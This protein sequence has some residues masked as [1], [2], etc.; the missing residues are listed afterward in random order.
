MAEVNKPVVLVV[1]DTP[2]NI[3]ILNELLGKE[4]LVRAATSG[5]AALEMVHTPPQPDLILL[6]I[7]MPEMDGYEVCIELKKNPL[8]AHIPV[9]FV[10]AM[11]EED[12]EAKG[13]DLG[14]ADYITKPY[15]PRLVLARVHNHLA[16]KKNRDDLY[17]MVNQR[18]DEIYRT[19]SITIETLASL[20]ETRDPETGRHIRRTQRYVRMLARELRSIYPTTWPLS[21]PLIDLIYS[22]APLH[23]IGKVGIPDTILLKPGALTVD[24]FEIMKLHTVYGYGALSSAE[25][26]LG[27]SSFLRVGAEIAYTHHEKWD[28][29]GYP[30]QLAGTDI[31]MSGRLMALADVYD[32]LV[33]KRVYK[34]PLTHEE[35]S[36]IILKGSGLHFDPQVTAAFAKHSEEFHRVAVELADEV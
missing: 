15:R 4:Y 16:V 28:G 21:D 36:A 26:Q 13:L 10:T 12:D 32:A 18:T 1:D 17:E 14:A 22:S 7:M 11:T 30:C 3:R 5:R 33:T 6:D 35:A 24:E 27:E 31:P 9:I 29:S 20:A 34:P 8:T 25:K 19:R 23:D 2:T